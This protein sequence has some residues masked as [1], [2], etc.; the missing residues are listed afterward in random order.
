MMT[1]KT[2]RTPSLLLMVSVFGTGCLLD[3]GMTAEEGVSGECSG[4]ECIGDGTSGSGESKLAAACDPGTT[5]TAWATNC[6]TSPPA[7]TAGTWTAGGPD[8]DHANFKLIKESAH[9][10]IY[11][12]ESTHHIRD[13]WLKTCMKAEVERVGLSYRAQGRGSPPRGSG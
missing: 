10:A 4:G 13:D 8:P 2:L 7:C 9:F 5:T 1:H 12:D 6:P 11:S 3:G